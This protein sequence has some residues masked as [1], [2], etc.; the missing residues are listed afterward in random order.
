MR[1]LLVLLLLALTVTA[2]AQMSPIRNEINTALGRDGITAEEYVIGIGTAPKH[3]SN[4]EELAMDNAVAEVYKQVAENFRAIIFANREEHFHDNVAEHYSTVAQLPKV[5]VKLPRIVEVP[6]PPGRSSDDTNTYFIAAF[7]R[8]EIV[9]LYARNAEKLRARINTTLAQNKLGD[10]A[11]AAQQ[12]LK[13]YRDYEELKEAELIMIGAEYNSNPREAFR[14]LYDY[15]KSG[16]SQQDVFNYLD[17]YFQNAGPVLLNKTSGIATL[18]ATQ[19]E[20]QNPASPSTGTVQLDQF[21]YGIAE[22]TG[23]FSAHFVNVL[24]RELATKGQVVLATHV[25]S[26]HAH[27]PIH[28]LGFGRGVDSRLTGTYWERGNKVTLRT[29][30]RDVNTGEFQAVAIVRFDKRLLTDIRTDRY[31]PANYEHVLDTQVI[32]AKEYLGKRHRLSIPRSPA[33]PQPPTPDSGSSSPAGS[34]SIGTTNTWKPDGATRIDLH[35]TS[36]KVQV[37]TEKGFGAQTYAIGE[38]ARFFVSVNQGAYLRVLYE[39]DKKWSQLV[40][41]QYV[42]PEQATQWLEL[43]GDFV[44]AEP[45]GVG[46]LEVQAKTTPFDPITDFY[47]ED[48]YRYIGTPPPDPSTLTAA[49]K[50]EA[51]I[52]AGYTRKGPI[53]KNFRA[54]IQRANSLLGARKGLINTDFGA[55]RSSG[56]ETSEETSSTRIYLTTIPQ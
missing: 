20:I 48:G 40:E 51:L 16:N 24:Q 29:T 46:I 33:V 42:K 1:N 10:P 21:T 32:E 47:Y 45:I 11:Y 13:T 6:L 18:I 38:K 3:L 53:N 55:D 56:T 14:E 30:L 34:A 28:P 9:D 22:V 12:Y 19:F 44:F 35:N 36:F 7:S 8:Q 37:R 4:A 15:T 39:Q 26:D 2:H 41:D 25:T 23:G 43:P 54:D 31:K 50:M 17:T 52:A 27:R 49:A 5:A